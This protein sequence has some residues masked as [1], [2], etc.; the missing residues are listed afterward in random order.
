[1]DYRRTR[2]EGGTYFFTVNLADRRATLLVDHIDLLR[3]AIRKNLKSVIQYFRVTPAGWTEPR[4]TGPI[5]L[6]NAP[7]VGATPKVIADTGTDP[8]RHAVATTMIRLRG[9][10][11]FHPK[12][13]S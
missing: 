11:T 2:Q 5:V 3:D 10:K 1:M 4:Y 9:R 7:N 12:R 13:I 6:V 8:D